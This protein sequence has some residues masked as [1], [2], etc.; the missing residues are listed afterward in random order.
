[1]QLV[2]SMLAAF[3]AD[4]HWHQSRGACGGVRHRPL[5]PLPG[6]EERDWDWE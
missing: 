2:R 6:D 4:A 3:P 1:V 5:L